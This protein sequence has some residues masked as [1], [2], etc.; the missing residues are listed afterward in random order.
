MGGVLGGGAGGGVASSGSVTIGSTWASLM[1]RGA[2]GRGSSS[3]PSSR[4]ATNRL[5]HLPTVCLVRRSSRATRVFVRPLAHAKITRARCA[6]AC[7]VVGRRVQRSNASRSSSVSL[8]TGMGRPIA[9][10]VL[11]SIARTLGPYMLFHLFQTHETSRLRKK[12]VELRNPLMAGH[13]MTGS[14]PAARGDSAAWWWAGFWSGRLAC[15]V[16]DPHGI[17][18]GDCKGEDAFQPRLSAVWRLA[19]QPDGLEP[20]EHLLG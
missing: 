14:G 12:L 1:R 10:R 11:L 3:N 13:E 8:S 2:P 15:Q 9:M 19:E 20:A 7:A 4:A 17:L 5:R 16:P 18:D 6:N